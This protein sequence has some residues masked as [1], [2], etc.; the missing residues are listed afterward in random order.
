MRTLFLTYNPL[1]EIS[2][3]AIVV[4]KLGVETGDEKRALAGGD[5]TSIGQRG[6]DV[7]VAADAGDRRGAN[8]DGVERLI[9]DGGY[10]QIGLEALALAPKGIALDGDVHAA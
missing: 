9:A 3:H 6:E 4:G 10:G 7:H 5:G 8:E 1:H 2:V